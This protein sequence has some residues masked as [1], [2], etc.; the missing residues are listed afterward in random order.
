MLTLTQYVARISDPSLREKTKRLLTDTTF[1]LGETRY[2]G[3]PLHK[4][5]ASRFW[6]HGYI[7]GLLQHTVA[8]AEIALTL[9]RNV[10]EIYE[11]DIDKDV[12]LASIIVHDL[13]KLFVYVTN[14]S[15]YR[16]S[17]LGK[18]LDHLTLIVTEL[19]RR[20]FPLEVIHAVAAH[21]GQA[22]PIAPR[23]VEALI[24]YIADNADASF[25]GQILKAARKLVGED[26]RWKD[27]PLTGKQALRIIKAKQIKD[28]D[29]SNEM[30]EHDEA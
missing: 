9:C 11:G 7:G 6:H 2:N 18:R 3:L 20:E 22:S 8:A 30:Q 15:G 4:A 29:I 14:G 5:P 26:R 25:N 28:L 24:C 10:K 16:F 21:H 17:E 13:F 12:V 1:T 19:V 23:T 27:H